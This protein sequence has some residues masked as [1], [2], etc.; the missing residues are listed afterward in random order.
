MNSLT[1]LLYCGTKNRIKEVFKSPGKL[2]PYLLGIGFLVFIVISSMLAEMPELADG[3]VSEPN[4]LLLKG[5]FFGFFLM[6]FLT[7]S[8]AGLKGNSQYAMEDVNFLFVSPIRARTILLYG[9][10]QSFKVIIV[11]SWFVLFQAQWLSGSFGIGMGGVFLIWLGYVLFALACQ[12]LSIFLYAMTNGNRRRIFRAKI[13][14]VLAFVPAAI[15]FLPNFF[16]YDLGDAANAWLGSAIVDFTPLVGWAAAGIVAL[17]TGEIFSAVLFLGL[18]VIFVAALFVIIFVTDPDYYEHVAGATQTAFE[19]V[20]AVA[21]GDIQAT[22]LGASNKNAR[23]KGTGL[24]GGAGAS[25][26]LY[27]H[28]RESF[29]AKRFGLWGIPSLLYV[30]GA[31]VFA[32]ISRGD[33]IGE[34]PEA[35]VLSILGTMLLIGFFTMSSGRGSLEI[36]SHYIY[37]VPE[38]PFKK[39]LWANGEIVLKV[40]VEGVLI[41]GVAGIVFGAAPLNFAIAAIVY[42]TF[43]FYSIGTTLAFMRLTGIAQR[44][45]FL[46]VIMI[47][48][49]I[50]PLLPGLF[51]AILVA[52]LVAEAWALTVGMIIFAA[53]QIAA[54]MICFALSKGML[55]N[56]DMLS[57][58]AMMKNLQ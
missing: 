17:V 46:S 31:G 32:F 35:V 14:I 23:V 55:H 53:W 7:T 21:E 15:A 20:R 16:A 13:C 42:I 40:A 12:M 10:I 2:I 28:L 6:T 44:S 49:H 56:C 9:I 18:V 52:L 8:L 47:F 50:V 34:F 57:M 51:V 45:V 22:A 26:F 33:Y 39:W 38:N 30:V 58:D 37:M 48:L 27:K 24:N 36:Y 19:T 1:Y 4:F 29:R 3:E 41:F 11:G 25:V 43:A 5:I 54:G